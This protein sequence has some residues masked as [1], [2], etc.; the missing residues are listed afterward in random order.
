MCINEQINNKEIINKLTIKINKKKLINKQDL[1]QIR[2]LAFLNQNETNKV[3]K[4]HYN[5]T[6]QY[7]IHIFNI[8]IFFKYTRQNYRKLQIFILIESNGTLTKNH[9]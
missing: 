5:K 6:R 3:K 1:K 2:L 4:E 9:F 8:I 7:N